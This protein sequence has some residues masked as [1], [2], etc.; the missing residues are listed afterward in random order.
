MTFD[1]FEN[2]NVKFTLIQSKF[3]CDVVKDYYISVGFFQ[4][5]HYVEGGDFGVSYEQLKDI[6]D[7]IGDAIRIRQENAQSN[8]I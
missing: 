1:L 5:N 2:D 6:H 4:N 3:P 8:R 7:K